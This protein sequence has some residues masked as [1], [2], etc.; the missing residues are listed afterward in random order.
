MNLLESKNH[1]ADSSQL[2]VS[3]GEPVSLSIIARRSIEPEHAIP[4]YPWQY[5]ASPEKIRIGNP[6]REQAGHGLQATSAINAGH[7]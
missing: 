6:V 3:I 5:Q 4:V 1:A 7:H 2:G